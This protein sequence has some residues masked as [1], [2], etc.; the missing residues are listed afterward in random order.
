MKNF[1][2][3]ITLFSAL[4]VNAQGTTGEYV[5]GNGLTTYS[6]MD[7][8]NMNTYLPEAPCG[9]VTR[10][11][12]FQEGTELS[13]PNTAACQWVF[14]DNAGGTD[15]YISQGSWA[16]AVGNSYDLP[17]AN[18]RLTVNAINSTYIELLIEK[19]DPTELSA[20]FGLNYIYPFFGTYLNPLQHSCTEADGG[21]GG[22]DCEITTTLVS[23][24][25]LSCLKLTRVDL[26]PS[27]PTCYCV[28]VTFT[29]GTVVSFD[30]SFSQGNEIMH[31]YDKTIST[32]VLIPKS[33]EECNECAT[34]VIGPAFK[35][36]STPPIKQSSNAV[37]FPNPAEQNFKLAG[38]SQHEFTSIRVYDVNGKI[39]KTFSPAAAY[40][41]NDLPKGTYVVNILNED[42]QIAN[43]QLVKE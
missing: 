32:Y 3:I 23:C 15:H 38:I 36:E 7:H 17:A 4:I 25:G 41:V 24:E 22:D 42:L 40:S 14:L 9:T 20:V 19:I 2:F 12:R 43:L 26:D 39:V 8:L 28:R 5:A 6:D 35:T 18:I 31:C 16:A 11:T 34:R 27:C 13:T 21:G 10:F 37:L 30:A 33:V 1:L 29:D